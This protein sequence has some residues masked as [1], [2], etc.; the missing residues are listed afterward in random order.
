MDLGGPQ[1]VKVSSPEILFLADCAEVLF[2]TEGNTLR[3]RSWR[4][5]WGHPGSEAA[6]RSTICHDG[7]QGDP[8]SSSAREYAGTS[9]RGEEGRRGCGS[10]IAE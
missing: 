8:R 9:R 4:A 1:A 10:R 3:R 2:I 5:E 6:S 7:N